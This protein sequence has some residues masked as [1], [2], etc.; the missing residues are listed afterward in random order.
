M[1]FNSASGFTTPQSVV[2]SGGLSLAA[3]NPNL[4]YNAVVNG[5]AT[6]TIG[7]VPAN[8]K[9]TILNINLIGFAS[10][11]TT[12]TNTLKIDGVAVLTNYCLSPTGYVVAF[13][14]D[15]TAS[16]ATGMQLTAGQVLA[17][18]TTTNSTASYN[19]FIYEEV[20]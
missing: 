17:I 20:V 2:I 5:A 15:I 16:Y 14:C 10:A 18:T 9:W 1:G 12:G 3:V 7:T 11:N 8:R 19:I 6:T 4:K 13:P